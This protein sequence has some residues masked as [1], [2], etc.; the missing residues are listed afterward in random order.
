MT[1]QHGSTKDQKKTQKSEDGGQGGSE[2]GQGGIF[3][4]RRQ[5]GRTRQMLQ[6]LQRGWVGRRDF[7]GAAHGRNF[8]RGMEGIQGWRCLISKAKGIEPPKP[9]PKR[10]P[11]PKPNPRT[12]VGHPRVDFSPK[13]TGPDRKRSPPTSRRAGC[14]NRT[15]NA[16]AQG[17]LPNNAPD[18]NSRMVEVIIER[19]KPH[20]LPKTEAGTARKADQDED[21]EACNDRFSLFGHRRRYA[22]SQETGEVHEQPLDM[23]YDQELEAPEYA[24]EDE[25]TIRYVEDDE[26]EV[27]EEEHEQHFGGYC[28]SSPSIR[29]RH[30]AEPG[31]RSCSADSAEPED[32]QPHSVDSPVRRTLLADSQG[33]PGSPHHSLTSPRGR[34][35]ERA[36]SRSRSPSAGPTRYQPA[37]TPPS[38]IRPHR[39]SVVPAQRHHMWTLSLH[40]PAAAPLLGGGGAR[41]EEIKVLERGG[42]MSPSLEVEDDQEDM[43]EF[44]AEI[45]ANGFEDVEEVTQK[46]KSKSKAARETKA[47]ATALVLQR[48]SRRRPRGRRRRALTRCPGP[49]R[50]VQ[51][52]GRRRGGRGREGK[53]PVMNSYMQDNNDD[54]DNDGPTATTPPGP[55]RPDPPARARRIHKFIKEMDTFAFDVASTAGNVCHQDTPGAVCMERVAAILG[56]DTRQDPR[57]G[58]N[59]NATCRQALITA[60]GIDDEFTADMIHNTE[61]VYTR[62]PWLKEWHDKLVAQAVVNY[63]EKNGAYDTK[64]YG[65]HV[66]GFVVDP[67]GDASYVFGAGDEFK[68]MRAAHSY[69]LTDQCKDQEHIFGNIELRKRGMAAQALRPAAGNHCRNAGTLGEHELDPTKFQMKWNAKFLDVAFENKCRIRNYPA[70]LEDQGHIIGKKFD[71]KKIRVET[72]KEFM[73]ALMKANRQRNGPPTTTILP[74]SAR[75]RNAM[76]RFVD[77]MSLPLEEQGEVP[78]I[79][80]VDGTALAYVKQSKAYDK[81]LVSERKRADKEE[82]SCVKGGKTRVVALGVLLRRTTASPFAPTQR[83]YYCRDDEYPRHRS[84]RGRSPRPQSPR[85]PQKHDSTVILMLPHHGSCGVVPPT[86]HVSQR[87]PIPVMPPSVA[88]AATRWFRRAGVQAASPRGL[89]AGHALVQRLNPPRTPAKQRGGKE[90]AVKDKPIKRKQPDTEPGA[91]EREPKHQRDMEELPSPRHKLRFLVGDKKSRSFYAKGF[92]EVQQRSIADVHTFMWNTD[93]AIYGRIPNN[94]TPVLATEEDRGIYCAEVKRLRLYDTE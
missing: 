40:P 37:A 89:H 52:G 69:A 43:E 82:K 35:A 80:N 46:K 12:F 32:Q 55:Y 53:A 26:D 73:P 16:P 2:G 9:L 88:M 59:L 90:A 67:R 54:N 68:E 94:H 21:T 76:L 14:R 65:V 71:V 6:T 58:S 1:G 17:A 83:R 81:E 8:G 39:R 93:R 27:D 84:P 49:A 91:M 70:A 56:G 15:A 25:S 64:T 75:H 66:W 60:C 19:P 86:G 29:R 79:T 31:S 85:L 28:P 47:V 42:R 87:K 50:L 78:L 4:G 63:R 92:E 45:E 51:S 5:L 18:I 72:F 3:D 57:A 23:L 11:K 44:E 13:L 10:Q 36:G 61:A 24:F 20:P 34:S 30:S 38:H 62:L 48:Q 7:D 74:F 77:E 33:H 22:N 41:K